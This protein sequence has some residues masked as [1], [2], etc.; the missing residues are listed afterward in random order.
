MAG[1]PGKKTKHEFSAR[2]APPP[3]SLMVRPYMFC[4]NTGSNIHEKFSKL[5]EGLTGKGLDCAHPLVLNSDLYT[6][7][8]CFS[9]L[10]HLQILKRPEGVEGR[11]ISHQLHCPKKLLLN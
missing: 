6:H 9:S 2:G 4:N 11:L 8:K 3:R 1:W 7:Q 5:T 10:F